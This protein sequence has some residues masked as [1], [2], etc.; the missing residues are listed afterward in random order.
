MPTKLTAKLVE[1]VKAEGGR[2]EISDQDIPALRLIV[3]PTGAK[4]WALRTRIGGKPAKLTLG[5][6]EAFTLA[7]ARAW[8]RNQLM[9]VRAG[10]DPRAVKRE[11]LEAERQRQQAEERR[12]G[13]TVAAICE[14]WIAKD[15]AGNRTADEVRRTMNKYVISVWGTRPLVEIA[16]RDVIELIGGVA[17]TAPLRANRVLA[18]VSRMCRWACGHDIIPANPCVGV[19]KQAKETQRDRV[20]DDAE[21]ALVARAAGELGVFG[22][23]VRALIATGCR[24][25][26][27]FAAKRDELSSDG[28]VLRL[29]ADLSKNGVGRSIHLST[30]AQEIIAELPDHGPDSYLFSYTGKS[31]YTAW[32]G[33]KERLDAAVARLA[34][35][36][37]PDWRLHDTR[38]SVATGLQRLGERLET[39]EAVL[40]HV[41]GSRGGI[42]AVYQRHKFEAEAAVALDRWADHLRGLLDP[43]A[44]GN[45]MHLRRNA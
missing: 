5:S 6:A 19:N 15:Q 29:P 28:T 40:G 1:H 33:G 10:V 23:G 36:E 4:S 24:R 8:A 13:E 16:R 9:D 34:G 41:S 38:R 17:E 12:K 26:E 27:I 7:Q 42:V 2:Q 35:K 32:S 39:I 14:K 3:S 31:P 45:V 30:L 43:S 22:L 25:A 18:Y 37:L 44:M 20:L 21:L 11:R